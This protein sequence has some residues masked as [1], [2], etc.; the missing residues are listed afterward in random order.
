MQLY[1][2]SNRTLH[3]HHIEW[4]LNT[5]FSILRYLKGNHY[6]QLWHVWNIFVPPHCNAFLLGF[7]L[8]CRY[9]GCKT[10]YLHDENKL[11]KSCFSGW[12]Q[13]YPNT[14]S[15]LWAHRAGIEFLFS[16]WALNPISCNTHWD[17]EVYELLIWGWKLG[18][19]WWPTDQ[20]QLL[21]QKE[22]LLNNNKSSLSW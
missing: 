19:S 12:L 9:A 7:N 14:W 6:L 20:Q 11:S 22:S 18:G 3:W 15:I 8:V 17:L 5:S 4:L 1:H 2:I 21:V 16:L 10:A 13:Y